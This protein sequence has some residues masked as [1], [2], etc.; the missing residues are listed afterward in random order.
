MNSFSGY[1]ALYLNTELAIENGHYENDETIKPS[2]FRDV[3]QSERFCI[4]KDQIA[5]NSI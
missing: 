4:L 5:L 2:M 3:A 1:S